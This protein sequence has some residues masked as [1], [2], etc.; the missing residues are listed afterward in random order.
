MQ[1]PFTAKHPVFPAAVMRFMPPPWNVDVAVEEAKMPEDP[2]RE[3]S[4]VGV[5]VPIPIAPL[6]VIVVVPVC[7]D[8][9]KLER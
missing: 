3:N 4:V 1:V 6:L 7:P 9:K 8:A 5:V 2:A